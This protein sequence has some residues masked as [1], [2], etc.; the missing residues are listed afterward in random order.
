MN[1]LLAVLLKGLAVVV[2][3]GGTLWVIWWLGSTL[4]QLLGPALKAVLPGDGPIQYRTGMG[5]AVGIALVFV[6][7]LLTGLV[8]FRRLFDLFGRLLEKI[9]LVKSLYGG[10]T[11][12]MGFVS[13]GGAAS[14][15]NKAVLYQ[16]A[17]DSHLLGFVTQSRPEA[18]PA[19]V[20]EGHVAVYLP[21]SYQIGGFTVFVPKDKVR[22]IDMSIEEAMRYAITAGMS[23][24]QPPAE[25]AARGNL[26]RIER[27]TGEAEADADQSARKTDAT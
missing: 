10:L 7:G 8:V 18:L 24:K 5:I 16:A 22:T 13:K 12:L 15:A 2:P 3:I 14:E 17:P 6:V 9:P 11:D 19:G 26:D 4:E 25:G 20:A 21:M 1:K 23:S 27:R